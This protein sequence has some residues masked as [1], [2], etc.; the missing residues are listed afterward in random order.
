MFLS[1]MALAAVQAE[2]TPKDALFNDL[3][4]M[5]VMFVLA[6]STDDAE[7]KLGAMTAASYYVGR[8][9][10]RFPGTNL[11]AEIQKA[12]NTL[13]EGDLQP[14][15]E[16]CANAVTARMENIKTEAQGASQSGE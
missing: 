2:A 8:I 16:D 6:D 12:G 11:V 7:S 3:R 5:V 4:C 14:V 15:I 1:M 13:A 10:G 9:D